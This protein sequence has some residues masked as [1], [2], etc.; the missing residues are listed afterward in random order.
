MTEVKKGAFRGNLKIKR[1]I[2]GENVKIVGQNAFKNCKNLSKITVKRKKIT[3]G[4]GAVKGTSGTLKVKG[5][6]TA[7]TAFV[8]K[9]NKNIK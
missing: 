8:K 1:V 7:V 3:V 2:L 6:R 4:K 9:G 5:S